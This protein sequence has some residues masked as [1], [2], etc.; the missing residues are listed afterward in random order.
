MYVRTP[1]KYDDCQL[2][3]VPNLSLTITLDW[4]CLGNPRD[5][6]SVMLCVKE[7]VPEH[8]LK[9]Q[10]DSWISFRYDVRLAYVFEQQ[11]PNRCGEVV[12]FLVSRSQSVNV[13]VSL[14]TASP[15]RFRS[16]GPELRPRLE[17]FRYERIEMIQKFMLNF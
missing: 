7:K 3:H 13:H 1:S 15:A 14:E 9:G 8:S 16:D 5:H 12:I 10:H 2:L 4:V 11:I 17:M 6:H